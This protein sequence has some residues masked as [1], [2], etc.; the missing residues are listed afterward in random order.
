MSPVAPFPRAPAELPL[1][2][3][4]KLDDLNPWWHNLPAPPQ[5]ALRRWPFARLRR[6]LDKGIAPATVLRGPRRV[7]K[8]VLL[9]QLIHQLLA[10]GVAPQRILYVP[11]DDLPSLSALL[12]PVLQI[13]RWFE[14]ARLGQSFN[15][16]AHAGQPAYL[17][18]DE[19]QNL[20][21]WAPQLKSLVDHSAVRALV[22]GSSSL[23]IA[24]GRDSLAG[25]ITTLDLGPLHLREIAELRSGHSIT[26][27]WPSNGLDPLLSPDF[28]RDAKR[29]AQAEREPRRQAFAAFSERG[30]YPFAH[31]HPDLPWSELADYL[32]ETVI[33]RA[34][35][36]D[37]R[38]GPRG[39]QRD[40]ALIEAIF[41]LACRYSGQAPGPSV[42][43]PDLRSL[44]GREVTWNRV[45]T[46]LRLLDDTML[47]RLVPPLELRLKRQTAPAK[48][49]LADHALRAVRMQELVP[50]DPSALA[51]EP[52]LADLAG[53]IA[54]GALG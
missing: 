49:C 2:L 22:T 47:L 18:F 5:P 54:E 13:P 25:R 50:L 33:R 52:Q 1:P 37:L 53:R 29:R 51:A 7:G 45:L 10:E 3:L 34:V 30:A 44:L 39:R 6:L 35:Q 9:E 19:V 48:L 12:E 27:Y 17:F 16:A 8:T 31:Q 28:W 40:G 32:D 38:T 4:A 21:A 42:F 11:F 15:Q 36:H 26:P 46:Y 20:R 23:R 24:A 41:R 14:Q 43:V